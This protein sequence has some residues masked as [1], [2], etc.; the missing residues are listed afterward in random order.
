M[1]T[2]PQK[3]LVRIGIVTLEEALPHILVGNYRD[4]SRRIG[5]DRRPP[6][7]FFGHTLVLKSLRLQC[8]KEKGVVC[9]KCG[10]AGTHF[11]LEMFRDQGHP[12]LNLYAATAQGDVL[13]TMDHIRPKAQGGPN[14][15]SNAQTLCGPCNFKKGDDFPLEDVDRLRANLVI[16]ARQRLL[17]LMAETLLSA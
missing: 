17:G 1:A 7:V 4:L 16:E 10:L 8:F 6:V 9:A 11:A 5:S 13:M 15:L 14:H 12:H 2:G 3:S